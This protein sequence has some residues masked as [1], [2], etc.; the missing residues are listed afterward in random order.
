MNFDILKTAVPQECMHAFLEKDTRY[1]ARNLNQQR[2]FSLSPKILNNFE[3]SAIGSLGLNK[4]ILVL[5]QDTSSNNNINNNN[6]RVEVE[7]LTS[8]KPQTVNQIYL[9]IN[10]IISSN[11]ISLNNNNKAYVL[12][13][14]VEYNDGNIYDTIS[15]SLNQF[16]NSFP[17]LGL[18]FKV[19]Y[20]TQT[21]CFIE[22]KLLVDPSLEEIKLSEFV[23]NVVKFESG[24]F[25]LH[26]IKG[27]FYEWSVIREAIN[28][29]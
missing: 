27:D 13:V 1:D 10:K 20:Q 14:C 22:G 4:I 5:K 11:I 21:F 29:L 12:H 3:Y 24:E 19:N 18:K 28:T 26:K 25:Y 6:L 17:D 2:N 23:F 15:L 16:F 9:Y 8:R 7:N